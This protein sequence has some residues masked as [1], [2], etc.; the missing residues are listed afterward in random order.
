MAPDGQQLVDV[1]ADGRSTRLYARAMADL[2]PRALPGTDGARLPFFSPDGKSVAFFADGNLK[3]AP[4]AGGT[5][6]ILADAATGCGASWSPSGEIAFAP[7]DT[8][9]VFLVS[10]GGGTPRA[11]TTL[12]FAA[13]D[14]S[15][16][17]P[18]W[19]P[20]G[21]AV[22]VTVVAWSRETS[23]IVMVDAASGS[24][25]TVQ[26]GADFARYVPRRPARRPVTSF[27]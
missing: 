4:I 21:R 7:S 23:D 17:W 13:G 2:T 8:S 9:G 1:A 18:Q 25:R 3:K 10:D 15:H 12:D 14:N 5:P 24:R 20:G 26:E 11:L 27:S 19:L 16:R 22:L 6:A